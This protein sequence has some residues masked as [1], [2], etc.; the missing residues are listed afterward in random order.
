MQLR[1]FLLQRITLRNETR[2]KIVD[3]LW[4][5]P[6]RSFRRRRVDLRPIHVAQRKR[7]TAAAMAVAATGAGPGRSFAQATGSADSEADAESFCRAA[8]LRRGDGD[9]TPNFF[10]QQRFRTRK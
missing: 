7:A 2:P 9:A 1:N 10:G 4:R 8:Q 6:R 3:L 5:L